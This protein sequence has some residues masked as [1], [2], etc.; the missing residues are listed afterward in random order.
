MTETEHLTSPDLAD[1]LREAQVSR[2]HPALSQAALKGVG[3]AAQ[4]FY[5]ANDHFVGKTA[6]GEH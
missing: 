4:H 6:M 3:I 5:G 2:M 1:G